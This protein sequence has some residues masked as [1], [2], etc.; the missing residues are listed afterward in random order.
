VPVAKRL[1]PPVRFVPF[2][3]TPLGG[4]GRGIETMGIAV[5]A[6]AGGD[7]LAFLLQLRKHQTHV[8][9]KPAPPPRPCASASMTMM[10]TP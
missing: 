8:L 7:R 9:K 5:A 1:T 2:G 3:A 10:N 6:L 4:C